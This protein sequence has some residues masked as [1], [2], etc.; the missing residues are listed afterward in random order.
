MKNESSKE[1]K[2]YVRLFNGMNFWG[3]VY[4]KE[5]Q[6]VQDLLNDDRKFIPV[7]KLE[8]KKGIGTEDIYRNICLH[9]D[10]VHY[11]EEMIV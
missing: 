10:G 3:Y 11:I 8:D 5:G 4:I 1:V 9:K 2:V 7:K 6:R